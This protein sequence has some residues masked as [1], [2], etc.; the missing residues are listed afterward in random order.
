MR[1]I[2][3]GSYGDAERE[4]LRAAAT[5]AELS[6]GE[7]VDAVREVISEADGWIG[8]PPG[9]LLDLAPRLRWL[10]SPAAGVDKDLTP[11]VRESD[12]ILTS[13]AGN[14]GIPLAEHAVML[15]LML[16]RSASRWFEAQQKRVWDRFVHGELNGKT[17]GIVG[18]GN[19]GSD[20]ALKARAF[21]M[22]V[23]GLRRRTHL[24]APNVDRVYSRDELTEFL[25]ETD[26]VVVTAPRTTETAG[27][28]DR[29]AFAAMKPSAYFICI[30]RGGIADDEAL[31][32]A[33]RR[34][35]IAG[36]GLDAHGVEPLSPDSEFW[37]L[38]NVIVTPHNGATT[39]ETAQR[40]LDIVVENLRRFVN[41]EPL[42]NV[43]DKAAGY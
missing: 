18:L 28:F 4:R 36:A 3:I 13:S 35:V 37:R 41:G 27:L 21:H 7:R 24:P 43:V 10:H 14:G 23:L 42:L 30:S 5:L 1:I 2:V 25:T 9:D 39:A 29:T 31:L 38:P 16:S 22:R 32:D 26:F 8:A 34:G 6:F 12:V 17:V 19:A 40:G 15:M 20:L 11:R 33:L